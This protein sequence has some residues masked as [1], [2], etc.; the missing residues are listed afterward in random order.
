MG[1]CTF[2]ATCPHCRTVDQGFTLRHE[3]AHFLPLSGHQ[4]DAA[5]FSC[6]GCS[7]PI[8]AV[9]VRV[10]NGVGSLWTQAGQF[11]PYTADQYW[12]V[13]EM[14]P[15][16]YK[17]GEAPKLTPANVASYFNQGCGALE[18]GHWDTAGM[19]FG[20]ALDIAT[21]RLIR[22]AAGDD[23]PAL[24]SALQ[25]RID[26]LFEKNKLTEQLKDWAHI[27][28]IERNDATH[29]E[30]PFTKE[31]AEQLKSFTDIFLTYVFTLPGEIAKYRGELTPA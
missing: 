14:Y 7:K 3:Y 10:S 18:R 19:G 27:V 17:A 25:K 29:E 16:E 31:E 24:K 4:A 13:M 21:K 22:E 9:A 5:L 26:W 15:P 30:E 1:K 8:A 2:K 28:R 20:K 12:V 11:T 23:C 6:N